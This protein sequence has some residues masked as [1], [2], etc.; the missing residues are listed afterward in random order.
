M[1]RGFKTHIFI[2]P[3]KLT[4]NKLAG[5]LVKKT[6]LEDFKDSEQIHSR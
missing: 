5:P 3:E 6:N 2:R 4:Q 1:F